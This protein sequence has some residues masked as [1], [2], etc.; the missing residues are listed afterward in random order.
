M[1]CLPGSSGR[2]PS[3]SPFCSQGSNVMEEQD[4]REIG[5]TDPQHRRK[6]LQAARSLPKVTTH[7]SAPTAFARATSPRPPGPRAEKGHGSG[8][9]DHR[10]V[11]PPHPGG[12]SGE[13]RVLFTSLPS[14]EV[15]ESQQSTGDS[16]DLICLRNQLQASAQ[17]RAWCPQAWP[18]T[19]TEPQPGPP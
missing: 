7:S 10:G 12:P 6:L 13:H 18:V 14:P 2:R 16:K 5:I 1:S 19:C 8:R 11:S 15:T 4:L 9:A 17:H 3:H